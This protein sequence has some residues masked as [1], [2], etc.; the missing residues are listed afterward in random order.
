MKGD[1]RKEGHCWAFFAAQHIYT[2]HL[3]FG[4]E[5]IHWMGEKKVLSFQNKWD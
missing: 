2:R 4:I 3:K 5:T 1:P